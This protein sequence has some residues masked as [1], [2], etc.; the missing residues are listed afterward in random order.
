VALPA[1]PPWSPRSSSTAI[2]QM[3]APQPKRPLEPHRSAGSF[4]TGADPVEGL[5]HP[6]RPS[7]NHRAWPAQG[8]GPAILLRLAVRIRRLLSSRSFSV[9]RARKAS[10]PPPSWRS[11]AEA[12][13]R[14]RRPSTKRP[15]RSTS[16]VGVDPPW[17]AARS[18]PVGLGE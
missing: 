3:P 12:F 6:A 10:N 15:P 4:V 1:R 9:A 17:P 14:R 2:V 8:P 16:A 13:G 5:R 18:R 11:P 7:G